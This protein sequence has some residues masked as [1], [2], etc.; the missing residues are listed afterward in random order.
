MPSPFEEDIWWVL[1]ALNRERG[2]PTTQRRGVQYVVID[3]RTLL[4]PLT[5]SGV[6]LNPA[7]QRRALE[8]LHREG[9]IDIEEM[10]GRIK[11][12]I[13]PP[14]DIPIDWDDE[15]KGYLENGFDFL[16]SEYEKK[17]LRGKSEITL[18]LDSSGN[19]WKEPRKRF[20]YSM[21]ES[22]GRV[23][24]IQFLLDNP[25]FQKTKQIVAKVG[26]N[27]AEVLRSEIS[28][29]NKNAKEKLKLSAP[30]IESKSGSGYRLN[31]KYKLDQ[32]SG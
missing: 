30:L 21:K 13:M 32:T 6:D 16:Y 11:I 5:T 24:I 26:K 22:Q 28:K 7:R 4:L 31:P 17:F 1:K 15:S 27:T 9:A 8:L 12:M 2:L 25:G 3:A 14:S 23:K 19:L 18:Y 29:I 20:L 10:G